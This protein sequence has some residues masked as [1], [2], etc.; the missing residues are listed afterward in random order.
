MADIDEAYV[1][2]KEGHD[3]IRDLKHSLHA[4]V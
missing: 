1:I 3:E 2:V 4:G